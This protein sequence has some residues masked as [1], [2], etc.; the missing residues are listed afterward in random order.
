MRQERLFHAFYPINETKGG[1]NEL[2]QIP[3]SRNNSLHLF[4]SGINRHRT[5]PLA[6]DG[7]A[8]YPGGMDCSRSC[9]SVS[10]F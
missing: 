4:A 1:H 7:C 6:R 8:R 3:L 2:Q 5:V 9:Q 10:R